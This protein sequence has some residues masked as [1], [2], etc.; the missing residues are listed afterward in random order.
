[1]LNIMSPKD[2][3]KFGKYNGMRDKHLQLCLSL[4]REDKHP[5]KLN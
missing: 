1:M 3:Y 2:L 4:D 5:S